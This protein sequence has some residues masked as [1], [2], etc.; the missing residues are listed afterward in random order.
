MDRGP[1]IP[2]LRVPFPSQAPFAL[3]ELCLIL[4][5]FPVF[6]PKY[7]LRQEQCY[8]FC[9]VVVSTVRAACNGASV[10]K[11]E[12]FKR[13]GKF[14]KFSAQLSVP[15]RKLFVDAYSLVRTLGQSSQLGTP[16]SV[17]LARKDMH[18]L[19]SML[20]VPSSEAKTRAVI[21]L[22]HLAHQSPEHRQMVAGVGT[23][24]KL[25]SII[26]S[27]S[28]QLKVHILAA[29]DAFIDESAGIDILTHF[30]LLSLSSNNII[31]YKKAVSMLG[32]I[33][34][35]TGGNRALVALLSGISLDLHPRFQRVALK[36]IMSCLNRDPQVVTD[37]ALVLLFNLLSPAAPVQTRTEAIVVL[38]RLAQQSLERRRMTGMV[39]PCPEAGTVSDEVFRKLADSL[40]DSNATIRAA[41]ADGLTKLASH[42][43]FLPIFQLGAADANSKLNCMLGSRIPSGSSFS[44]SRTRTAMSGLSVKTQ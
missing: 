10:V 15:T 34:S 8:W 12:G 7:K 33:A 22:T 13:A 11:E 18:M 26:D 37:N 42:C 6:S 28:P 38:T 23:A 4:S 44:Y 20:A 27:A 24:T 32:I 40:M 19:V 30:L 9:D 5:F 21:A 29:L 3:R 16:P 14:G 43:E 35:A 1:S 39:S 2:V 25:I 36:E 41:A 31:T 17:T